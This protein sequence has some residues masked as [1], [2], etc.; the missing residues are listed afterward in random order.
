M[1]IRIMSKRPRAFKSS[2]T[3][4]ELLFGDAQREGRSFSCSGISAEMSRMLSS[5]K[6]DFITLVSPAWARKRPLW[7]QMSAHNFSL[8]RQFI[9]VSK[10]HGDGVGLGGGLV[11]TQGA[12]EQPKVWQ[13]PGL[14][15][16]PSI[17]ES[18]G[19]ASCPN[20]SGSATPSPGRDKGL[21]RQACCLTH[22]LAGDPGYQQETEM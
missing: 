13:A 7:C 8:P 12:R 16:R 20:S 10:S 17:K 1:V 6:T 2:H 14:C 4:P 9:W 21:G 5:F 3:A 15:S 11:S 22:L 19:N 18:K